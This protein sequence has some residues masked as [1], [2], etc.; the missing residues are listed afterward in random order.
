M[1]TFAAMSIQLNTIA[2]IHKASVV[3]VLWFVK[4]FGRMKKSLRGHS[5]IMSPAEGG[6][7]YPR[8]VTSGDKGEGGGQQG[9]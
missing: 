1:K 2:T 6:G 5:I 4:V 9:W 7:G 3:V 8:V